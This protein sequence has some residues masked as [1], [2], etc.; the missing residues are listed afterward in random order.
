[1]LSTVREAID[2]D[3]CES[4]KEISEWGIIRVCPGKQ[5]EH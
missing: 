1:V 4:L 3:Y 2:K 5:T